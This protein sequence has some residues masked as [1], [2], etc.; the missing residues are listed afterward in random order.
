MALNK[1][2][3]RVL[4]NVIARLKKPNL[5]C[6][7]QMGLEEL[8]KLANENGVE[9]V[10]RIYLDTWVIPTLELLLKGGRYSVQLAETISK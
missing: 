10:S 2:E 1:S 8:V 4:Q 9:A 7:N 6:C 3:I 5:G